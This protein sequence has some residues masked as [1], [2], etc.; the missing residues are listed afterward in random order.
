MRRR[1]DRQRWHRRRAFRRHGRRL[2]CLRGRTSRRRDRR[3]GNGLLGR[4]CGRRCRHGR[5]GLRRSRRPV[6]LGRFRRQVGELASRV[7]ERS[8]WPGGHGVLGWRLR[9]PDVALSR[10]LGIRLPLRRPCQRRRL[11]RLSRRCRLGLAGRFSRGRGGLSPGGGGLLHSHCRLGFGLVLAGL[12]R[13]GF[14]RCRVRLR[15]GWR[16]FLHRQRR[17]GSG[18]DSIVGRLFRLAR[19]G[20]DG[21]FDRLGAHRG[22]GL[23]RRLLLGF[24]GCFDLALGGLLIGRGFGDRLRALSFDF[25]IRRLG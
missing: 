23:Q 24:D 21:G 5:D 18:L 13:R 17:F 15:P 4:H 10:E 3:R 8:R 9:R 14:F 20:F 6:R 1:H 12:F 16:R 19:F 25:G 11:H 7:A 22:L 2:D